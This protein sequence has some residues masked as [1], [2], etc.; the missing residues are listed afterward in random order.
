M[1]V[2]CHTHYVPR[3]FTR[4]LAAGERPFG[5]EQGP[6][7]AIVHPAGPVLPVGYAELHEPA[8]KL[9]VLDGQGVDAA[10]VSLTPHLF[11]QAGEAGV[12][13]ARQANEE[14]AEFVAGDRLVGIGTLPMDRP[15]EAAR[16][17]EHGVREL[18]LRG[19]ILGTGHPDGRLYE[20]ADLEPLF[21]VAEG[22]GV[23]LMLHPFYAGPVQDQAHFLANSIGV[24]LD[25]L[26][27]TVA[28][29]YTGLLDRW[30]GVRLILPHGG[31]YLP[32]QLGRLDNGWRAKPACR[33]GAE[34]TPSAYLEQCFFDTVLHEPA[35]LRF[36][37]EVAGPERLLLG[38]DAPYVTGE[39]DPVGFV[40]A[41][42][43][44]PA[45]LGANAARLFGIDGTSS[46]RAL[47]RR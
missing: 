36:L 21:E 4:A 42:G 29:F 20:R 18:G 11:V 34:R 19:A 41:A 25:T 46:K 38:T 17:L 27:G 5:Y 15:A 10:V 2:D 6:A 30:P 35:A 33:G 40:T 28:I 23:P 8:A 31:G 1:I 43:V 13:F 9:A 26:L 16:E 3:T 32:Y 45:A 44:D 39:A 12:R 37:T 47:R 14:L 7:G 24:P 22:L